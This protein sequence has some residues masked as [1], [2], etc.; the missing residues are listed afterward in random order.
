MSAFLCFG[1]IF[2]GTDGAALLF[3]LPIP[4]DEPVS[5]TVLLMVQ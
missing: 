5:T 3:A 2:S 4:P 1:I